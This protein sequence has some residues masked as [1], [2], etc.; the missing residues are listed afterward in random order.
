RLAHRFGRHRAWLAGDAAHLTGPI[1]M[2]SMNVGL[3]EGYEL[4]WRIAEVLH[5]GGSPELLEE[6]GRDFQDEW[7]TLLGFDG[8]LRVRES[9]DPWVASRTQRILPCLPASGEHLARLAH[10]LNLDV[11]STDCTVVKSRA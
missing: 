8:G 5:H 3:R 7:R 11:R 4:A 2:Q 1:G 9:T 6:Y 10:Q